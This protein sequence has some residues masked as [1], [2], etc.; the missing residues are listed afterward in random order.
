LLLGGSITEDMSC[1]PNPAFTADSNR[2]RDAFASEFQ[3][4]YQKVGVLKNSPKIQAADRRSFGSSQHR[5]QIQR[6]PVVEDRKNEARAQ[7]A[8]FLVSE[9][10]AAD[11]V[12]IVRVNGLASEHFHANVTALV[13]TKVDLIN[14]PKVESREDVLRAVDA[15]H[16]A[17]IS[18]GAGR[19]IG[20]LVNIETPK[21]LR[22]VFEIA[23]ADERVMG[24]QLGFT[25]FSLA[26][27]VQS[28][29]KVSLNAL[30]VAMCLAAA[31]AG[32]ACYDGA[33]VDVNNADAFRAEAEEAK[34][35]GFAGKSC[36]HPSQIALANAA[37]SP[38]AAEIE[39][40]RGLLAAA[41]EGSGR[42]VGALYMMERWWT[43][44]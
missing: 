15:M 10:A 18:V 16:T 21:G 6:P 22:L 42:G 17:E 20:L 11:K 12:T 5:L 29:N 8:E 3:C 40:A 24:L 34:A 44:R 9:K 19:E 2:P 39:R 4:R 28:T 13:G 35:L 31:E 25:D 30:R 33:F 14:V 32:I 37:F 43:A 23:T 26:C 27:G 38:N 36:I 41:E 7:V 1:S